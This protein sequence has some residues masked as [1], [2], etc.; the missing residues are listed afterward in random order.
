MS[1]RDVSNKILV[2]IG[3][4]NPSD[5]NDTLNRMKNYNIPNP[6]RIDWK[7]EVVNLRNK[8]VRIHSVVCGSTSE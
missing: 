5:P 8:G 2:M 3:D 7:E 6:R 4:A 1:W